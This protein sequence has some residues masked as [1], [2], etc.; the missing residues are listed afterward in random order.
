MEYV[1]VVRRR[2]DDI[3]HR[4]HKYIK[5]ERV[6]D[7]W[8]YYYEEDTND[9]LNSRSTITLA[10]GEQRI[11]DKRGKIDRA[12]D[13]VKEK[14]KDKLGYDERTARDSAVALQRSTMINPLATKLDKAVASDRALKAINAYSKTPLGKIERATSAIKGGSKAVKSL[15]K[16]K[17]A[18]H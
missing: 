4:Q 9:L 17:F 7:K 18:I 5:R 16:K 13:N 3:E 12:A 2:D 10:N 6:G 1:A 15:F 11:I 14:V 8:R